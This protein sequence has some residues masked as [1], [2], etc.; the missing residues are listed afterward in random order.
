[1]TVSGHSARENRLLAALPDESSRRFLA[2]CERVE[3]RYGQVLYETSERIRHVYFPTNGFISLVTRLD[4]G[5]QLEVGMVGDEGMVGMSLM[6]GIDVSPHQA[7][8]QGAGGSLRISAAAFRRN[9]GQRPALRL[10]LSGYLHV[11]MSQLAQTAACIHY[12]V[13]EARL[14]RWLLL[15]RDRAHSDQFHLTHEFLAHML[16]VRRVGITQAASSLHERG[17][18]DYRRG[19]ISILDGRGLQL[20]ACSCYRQGNRMYEKTLGFDSRARRR[21]ASHLQ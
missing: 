16:G 17:L 5:A 10:A 18:I 3:L 12:H 21:R 7:V 20:A 19:E 9:W 8:V 13:V 4:D 2:D 11:L 14:A 6:L 1:M 15:C